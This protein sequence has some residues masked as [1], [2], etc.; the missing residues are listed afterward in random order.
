MAARA[1]SPP[2]QFTRVVPRGARGARARLERRGLARTP[3]LAD[4]FHFLMETTW[5]RL[6][7]V[8]I[9]LYAGVN[10]LFALLY[11]A[12]G[13]CIANAQPGSFR[14]MFFF[15]VQTMA[16]IGY[17]VL[18][19][20]TTWAHGLVAIEALVGMLGIAMSTGLMFAKFSRA[21]ARVLFSNVSVVARR[22]GVPTLSFRVANERESTVA[23]ARI[24]LTLVRW[25][26]TAEGERMRRFHDLT[27]ARASTPVFALS[28]TVM[29]P[30][31]A[32]SPLA[33]ATND[34]LVASGTEIIASL[35][36]MDEASGQVVHERFSWI[37]GEVQWG[38]RLV[39]IFVRDADGNAWVDY[40]K[41]HSWEPEKPGDKPAS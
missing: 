36:G 33:G 31:D 34:A 23:E 10:S 19:P 41:F 17:G 22:D 4:L 9:A 21:R 35:S 30:I 16:T 15:S 25:E 1:P 8:F 24:V 13:D 11:M 37:A 32:K 27:L 5:P 3:L 18:A 2:S 20:K 26:T 6:F 38:A 7:G 14:D 29:H 12:G 40:T 28:W 39:D